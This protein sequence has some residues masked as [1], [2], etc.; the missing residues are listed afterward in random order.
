MLKTNSGPAKVSVW[1]TSC[2]ETVLAFAWFA[3]FLFGL[4]IPALGKT[5]YQKP[6]KEVLDVLHAPSTPDAIINPTRTT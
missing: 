6:P 4:C 1:H 3:L 2:H 5:P